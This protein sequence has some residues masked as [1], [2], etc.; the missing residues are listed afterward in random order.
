MCD[1][2]L[3]IRLYI[4]VELLKNALRATMDKVGVLKSHE[5]PT[6]RIAAWQDTTHLHLTVADRGV[7]MSDS[8]HASLFSFFYSTA[9]PPLM[10][11]TYS[12]QFGAPFTGLGM[13]LGSVQTYAQLYAGEVAVQSRAGQGTTV[14]VR[15]ARKGDWDM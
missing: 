14:H 13:G 4:R 1:T 5:A 11:Y 7:G 10:T 6:V 12:R 9:P 15:L 3:S 2:G 8:A